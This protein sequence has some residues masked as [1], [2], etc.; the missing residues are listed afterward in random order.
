MTKKLTEKRDKEAK[1]FIPTTS[2]LDWSD[3]DVS[4]L[5]TEVYKAGFDACHQ[6]LLNETPEFDEAEVENQNVRG[7]EIAQGESKV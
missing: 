3:P 7:N 6:A 5:I 2:V 4:D 1:E